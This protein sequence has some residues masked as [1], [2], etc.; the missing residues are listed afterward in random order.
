MT[1]PPEDELERD[2]CVVVERPVRVA[3]DV[4]GGEVVP[5]GLAVDEVVG[6]DHAGVA[7]V[8]DPRVRDVQGD[9]KAEEKRA[10]DREPR[11][12]RGGPQALPGAAEPH[13]DHPRQE[14]EQRRVGER[15]ADPDVALVEV[16]LRDPER[17]QDEQVQVDHP[18]LAAE[19]EEAEEEDP[20]QR[21]PDVR[22]VQL[23]AE[24]VR[25]AAG[26][27]PGDLVA[28]PR[29]GDPPGRV[30]HD[31]LHPLGPVRV[32]VHLPGAGLGGRGRLE[33]APALPL[34]GDLRVGAGD[35]DRR[36]SVRLWSDS[37]RSSWFRWSWSP[38]WSPESIRR[39]TFPGRGRQRGGP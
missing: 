31:H 33:M 11:R 20:G 17:Q 29:L 2:V 24:L 30:V 35:P 1:A 21:Q 3:E 26:H 23:V 22:R 32:E 25:V 27:L 39:P 8:D 38:P 12:G 14:V 13:P 16:D 37:P 6:P 10:A 7:D 4:V 34:R 28:G 9:A 36:D 19:V 5:D 15:D 18:P